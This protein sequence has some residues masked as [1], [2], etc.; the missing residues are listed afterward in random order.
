MSK[1]GKWFYRRVFKRI[2]QRHPIEVYV[3]GKLISAGSGTI[4]MDTRDPRHTHI[5]KIK[6]YWK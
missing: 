6:G 5:V 4:T 3:N 1:L 2:R